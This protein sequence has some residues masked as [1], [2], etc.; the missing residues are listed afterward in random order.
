M[1]DT[2][3]EPLDGAESSQL[4][5]VEGL[6]VAF[7]VGDALEEVVRGVSFE[8]SAGEFVGLVGESGSGKTLTSLA[9]LRLV[10]PPGRITSGRVLLD[11]RDLRELSEKEM[12]SVR[13]AR[14]GMVFQEP[15][16]ALN[17]VF[18]VGFQIAEA[19]RAHGDASRSQARGRAEELLEMVAMPEPKR[20]LKDYPHQ[21]S[22]GQRQRVMIAIALASK[23]DLLLADEP[24]TAL[25]VTVQAQILE[26]MESLRR[27][28]GLAVLLITHDLAVV[29]E[30]CDRVV[31][32][33]AGDVVEEAP[34]DRLF[35]SPEHPYTQGLLSA[36]PRIDRE[37]SAEGRLTAIPGQV[38]EVSDRPP[39]CAFHPR[40]DEVM[41]RCR[42]EIPAEFAGPDGRRVRCFLYD[43]PSR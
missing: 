28:L 40:C 21:L 34:V 22:G 4:L 37:R 26:L 41:D 35:S 42:V 16:T 19:I 43:E 33:Y 9:L 10:P 11:G 23:P 15:M 39:G 38:P 14:I 20:R 27:E 13:G 5:A 12:C 2:A 31:V 25:D 29:A 24:T 30:T 6:S 32:M 3:H 36:L 8:V 1:A 18:T 7:P 17:P